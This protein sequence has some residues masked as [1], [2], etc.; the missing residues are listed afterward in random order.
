M[1]LLLAAPLLAALAPLLVAVLLL[2]LWVPLLAPEQLV[3]LL[4]RPA[5]ACRLYLAWSRT[6]GGPE[7][8]QLQLPVA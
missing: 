2:L 6:Q 5:V 3:L 8:L 1:V 7:V 4:R